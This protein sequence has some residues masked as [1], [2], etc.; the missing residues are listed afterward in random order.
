MTPGPLLR[1]ALHQAVDL[2]FDAIADD[3]RHAERIAEGKRAPRKRN[4]PPPPDISECSPQA[5]ADA[6]KVMRRAGLLP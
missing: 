4:L 6:E 2:I 1:R 3:K 5:I